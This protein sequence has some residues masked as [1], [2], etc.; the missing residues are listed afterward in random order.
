MYYT[1]MLICRGGSIYTGYT[2]DLQRRIREH[3][4]ESAQGAKYTRSH[5]PERLAAAWQTAEKASAC[6]LEYYIKQLTKKQK[7]R[8]IADG[9]LSAFGEKINAG[10]YSPADISQI[11]AALHVKDSPLGCSAVNDILCC[12]D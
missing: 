1:Y 8:L 4:G 3:S 2:A 11:N 6:R 5:P 10:D 7:L 9:D 12:R